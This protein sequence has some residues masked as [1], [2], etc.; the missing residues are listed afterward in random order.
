[1]DY[2][3]SMGKFPLI[4]ILCA[5]FCAVGVV[6]L[7]GCA[8]PVGLSAFVKDKE[9]EDI[10]EK[11]AGT[12]NLTLDTHDAEPG[13][14]AGNQKITG[15]DPDKYYMVEE[16]DED[17]SSTGLPQV[18]SAN[19]QRSATLTN[20]G[21][22][23]GG[24]ITGLTNRYHYRVRSA[25]PLP[26]DVPYKALTLPGSTLS[27][28][29]TNGVISLSEPE[30]DGFIVYTLT[31][32]SIPPY[33]IVE[34]PISPAGSA[35][36]AMRPSPN[37]DI[38]TL[39]N[40]GTVIDYV[41]FG[42]TSDVMYNFYVLRVVSDPV[43]LELTVTLL[44]YAGDNPPDLAVESVSYTQNDTGIITFTVDNAGQYDNNSFIWF[45]DGTQVEG[46]RLFFNLN[47]D[48]PE[49]KIVGDYII[50]VIASKDGIPYSATIKVEVLP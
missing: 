40:R 37:G 19:G 6:Y 44:P 34:I 43:W 8:P 47:K 2:S 15:L 14:K 24:E 33:E 17:G 20:I 16:W 35:K 26:G 38:I 50:T 31:P 29:N 36:P 27:A 10:I 18:V 4:T 32:P 45:V 46:T 22:V 21:K 12:V 25:G 23:E 7:G 48:L 5:V 3:V 1:M 13:L 9:V 28:P 41:F 39:I 11:G 30:G 49:Y 42:T